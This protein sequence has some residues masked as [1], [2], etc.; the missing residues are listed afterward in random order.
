MHPILFRLATPWGGEIPIFSYGVMLGV[1]FVVG[2]Y[3][4]LW[5][6]ERD[7][8]DRETMANCFV[9]TALGAVVGARLLYVATNLDE[10][11]SFAALLA[12]RNGGMVAYGG[13]L[14]GFGGSWLYLRRKRLPLIPWADVAV[15]SLASG[16]LVTRIGCYLFG[17]DFGAPLPEDAPQWL[18][19]A[20]TFPRWVEAPMADTGSPA[21]AQHVHD[22][23]VEPTSSA[24]LPVH[25]TQLY[26]SLLGL[27][28]LVTLL[29]LLPRR[30]FVGEAF[31]RFT[32]L[33]GFGRFCL[34]LLRADD[35]RGAL[36]LSAPSHV[37]YGVAFAV[38]AAA[39]WAGPSLGV[40][41][42][43]IRSMS[44][45]LAF[46]PAIGSCVL[47]WPT[48]FAPLAMARLSTS[49]TI[50][51]ATTACAAIAFRALWLGANGKEARPPVVPSQARAG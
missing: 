39:W 30:R 43:R 22:R 25:P 12:L 41:S 14:G 8:L 3:M 27:L 34:E 20:G 19:R 1:S 45:V 26:E 36:P 7:G 44:R 10:F 51:L 47:L 15:P 21:W 40:S 4:T 48:S 42:P 32:M 38:F 16:L 46:G 35:E 18:R 33:Y 37:L 31:L 29:R 49:Q 5:L 6:A 23:L 9:V 28:L 50:G 17:C 11:D 2:W 24:S 13:F